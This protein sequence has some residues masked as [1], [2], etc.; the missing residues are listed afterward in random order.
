MIGV[1]SLVAFIALALWLGSAALGAVG[2]G[3]SAAV[4]DPA[5]AVPGVAK[6]GCVWLVWVVVLLVGCVVF[7]LLVRR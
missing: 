5:A 3:V 2:V 7:V 4:A 6:V 1:L